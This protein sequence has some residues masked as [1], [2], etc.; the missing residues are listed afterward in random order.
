MIKQGNI[1]LIRHGETAWSLSGQHT[2]KTE[3]EL[4]ASGQMMAK[5]IGR[6]LAE[7]KFSL[8][9]S[10]PRVRA[11]ATCE[12][13]G[14]GD[15]AQIDDNLQEWDYGAY[16]GRTSADIAKEVPGWSIWRDGV[17][18]GE[19]IAQV[20]ARAEVVIKRAVEIAGDVALFA[21][22]HI[23]RILAARW[24]GLPAAGGRFFALGAGSI[25]ILAYEREQRV[26]AQ[27][28]FMPAQDA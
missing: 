6:Q 21:H 19:T 22:G 5:A 13:A 18:D 20:A 23:L 27:W 24:I 3:L 2:G 28:N 1:W 10:S 25:S 7:R 16:E 4:T 8:V 11:R 15:V 14:Y 9:L 26:I 17:R 12:L